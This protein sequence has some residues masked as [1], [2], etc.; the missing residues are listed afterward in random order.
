MDRIYR[1]YWAPGDFSYHDDGHLQGWY[2][3]F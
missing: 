2:L 1:T 3:K